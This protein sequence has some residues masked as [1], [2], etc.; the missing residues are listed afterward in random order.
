MQ[1]LGYQSPTYFEDVVLPNAYVFSSGDNFIELDWTQNSKVDK[2]YGNTHS[3]Y[4]ELTWTFD[5][6]VYA[7]VSWGE[8]L[9]L[10]GMGEDLQAKFMRG[11]TLSLSGSSR[12]ADEQDWHM[13]IEAFNCPPPTPANGGYISYTFRVYFLPSSQQNTEDL[14]RYMTSPMLKAKVDP[15]SRP[16]RILYEVTQYQHVG[17]DG[18]KTSYPSP[19]PAVM[20]PAPTVP[21]DAS[22]VVQGKYPSGAPSAWQLDQSVRYMVTFVNASGESDGQ[23]SDPAQV[24]SF[25]CPQITIPTDLT[26]V[27]TSRRVYRMLGGQKQ[28]VLTVPDNTATTCY[29]DLPQFNFAAPDSYVTVPAPTDAANWSA[30]SNFPGSKVW[31]PNNQVSYAVSYLYEYGET[32]L[33]PWCPWQTINARAYPNLSNVPVQAAPA[34]ASTPRCTGRKIYRRSC[35]PGPNGEFVTIEI[36]TLVQTIQDGSGTPVT[37]AWDPAPGYTSSIPKQGSAPARAARV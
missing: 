12:T 36:Q 29:D 19:A 26:N 23:W 3:S 8:G 35:T 25:S 37:T 32:Q 34:N 14:L 28:F 20:A 22:K 15:N 10:F 5:T 4:D 31:V 7:G 13:G 24:G 2:Q 1:S 16:W 17:A 6:S 21:T 9:E 33:G 27:A 18:T 30:R 11:F